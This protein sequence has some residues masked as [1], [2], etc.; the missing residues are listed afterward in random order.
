M[1]QQKALQMLPRLAQRA[2]RGCPRPH[3][4]AHRL[5]CQIGNPNGGQF[6]GPMQLRQQRCI[7]AIRLYSVACL[8]RDQ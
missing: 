3:Q 6:A 1:A 5:V 2:D 7:A 4:V 8:D